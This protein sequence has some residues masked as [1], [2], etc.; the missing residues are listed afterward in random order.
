VEGLVGGDVLLF[1]ITSKP[2]THG[3][4]LPLVEADFFEGG[5]PM[6]SFVL[7]QRWVTASSAVIR[8]LAGKISAQKLGEI[9]VAA[10]EVVQGNTIVSRKSDF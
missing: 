3:A 9:R 5:L 4:A 1:Q 10:C 6:E 2:S 7:P 8:R